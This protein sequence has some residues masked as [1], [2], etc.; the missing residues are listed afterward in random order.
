[1]TTRDAGSKNTYAIGG[2]GS[3]IENKQNLNEIISEHENNK[4]MHSICG[5][6]FE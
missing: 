6:N 5:Y 4:G 3:E 1:M 2:W